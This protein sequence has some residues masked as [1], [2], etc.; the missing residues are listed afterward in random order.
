M[1]EQFHCYLNA[2]FPTAELQ[3]NFYFLVF[4]KIKFSVSGN[5][6]ISFRSKKAWDYFFCDVLDDSPEEDRTGSFKC[7]TIL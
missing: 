2:F 7:T 3:T 5:T 6:V 4:L 1:F